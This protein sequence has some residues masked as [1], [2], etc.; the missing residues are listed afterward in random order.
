[1]D[2]KK[3]L[4]DRLLNTDEYIEELKVMTSV[5]EIESIYNDFSVTYHNIRNRNKLQHDV[6]PICNKKKPEF[7]DPETGYCDAKCRLKAKALGSKIKLMTLKKFVKDAKTYKND[8]K[9]LYSLMGRINNLKI[10]LP[11]TLP[12]SIIRD[13]EAV[14]DGINNKLIELT[15]DVKDKIDETKDKVTDKINEKKQQSGDYLVDLRDRTAA[16]IK[17]RSD[18]LRQKRKDIVNDAYIKATTAKATLL[19]RKIK[20]KVEKLVRKQLNDMFKLK[21]QMLKYA[22]MLLDMGSLGVDMDGLDSAI[23]S[24][25]DSV[26]ILKQQFD[27]AY[28]KAYGAIV[29]YIPASLNGE[30]INFFITPKSKIWKPGPKLTN[31]LP[32][33][34]ISISGS[35]MSFINWDM[36]DK[37]MSKYLAEI[38]TDDMSSDIAMFKEKCEKKIV[39]QKNLNKVK[40]TIK[41]M[42]MLTSQPLPKYENLKVSNPRYSLWAFTCWGS[43][44]KLHFGMLI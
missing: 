42:V 4:S 1:M 14:V 28:D 30:S 35:A 44:G 21:V 39:T 19:I 38:T 7:P 5:T 26:D 6:C 33:L 23:N 8:I 20:L 41:N 3:K 9:D 18:K 31:E 29:S 13:I 43:L 2:R 25:T 32:N 17:D 37:L 12:A 24:I 34:N 11:K 40:N 16:D 27:A 36:V 10:E 15:S 22:N